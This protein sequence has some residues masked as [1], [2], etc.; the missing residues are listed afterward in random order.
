[1]RAHDIQPRFQGP[2]A[3]VEQHNRF[4][5]AIHIHL[6]T[7]DKARL[8]CDS[9]LEIDISSLFSQRYRLTHAL[10]FGFSIV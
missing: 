7:G 4:A 8:L 10:P 5:H 3:H 2:L 1:M 6:I 9:I